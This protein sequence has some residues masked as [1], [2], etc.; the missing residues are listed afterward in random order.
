[1]SQY[2]PDL[3]GPHK[4]RLEPTHDWVTWREAAKL[5]STSENSWQYRTKLPKRT[6]SRHGASHHG[7]SGALYERAF[8][9]HVVQ[10]RRECRCGINVAVRVALALREQRI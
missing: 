8:L 4:G 5:L 10:I 3:L 9:E 7:G 6:R 2:Q 1:M